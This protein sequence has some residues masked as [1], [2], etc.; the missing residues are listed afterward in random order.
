MKSIKVLRYLIMLFVVQVFFA[1]CG[2]ENNSNQVSRE[3]SFAGI[4][5]LPGGDTK[6]WANDVSADGS[7]IV[8][9][10]TG[11]TG[12]Q[13]VRWQDGLLE[14]LPVTPEYAGRVTVAKSISP[15]GTV[16]VGRAS[17]NAAAHDALRWE[18][19]NVS[20][21]GRFPDHVDA[22][23]WANAASEG[24]GIIVGWEMGEAFVWHEGN[25]VPSR[26]GTWPGGGSYTVS[27]D[28]SPDGHVI[29]GAGGSD[30]PSEAFNFKAFIMRDGNT[31]VLDVLGIANNDVNEA[32][33]F[34]NAITPDGKV[35]V[36][37][38]SYAGADERHEY[39]PFRWKDGEMTG[40]GFPSGHSDGEARDV[41]ADGA[42][43]V[44][45]SQPDGAT[46]AS[47]ARA[48]IW[49]EAAGMRN[50]KKVLETEHGLDLAGWTLTTAAAISHDGAVIVGDGI[51]PSGANEG[52]RAVLGSR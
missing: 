44:G 41:S 45:Y 31:T 34:A 21:L 42:I 47:E 28:I 15:D 25:A 19:A 12:R 49:T 4:G 35:V 6:S 32:S 50:L 3:P 8:G 13:A 11:P 26:L 39:Q 17:D 23:N 43:V 5:D 48:F 18:G 46:T 51:S 38:S 20:F 7:I 1:S 29:V 16:I 24:G 10:S 52:W 14:S 33:S 22:P 36:G 37:A 9:G 40:L 27:N 30:K 2:K